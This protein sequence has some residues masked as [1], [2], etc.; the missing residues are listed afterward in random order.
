MT[1]MFIAQYISESSV[2][3]TKIKTQYK[4]RHVR[5]ITIKDN[6]TTITGLMENSEEDQSVTDT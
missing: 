2:D 1:T 4:C 3:C 6:H 5:N